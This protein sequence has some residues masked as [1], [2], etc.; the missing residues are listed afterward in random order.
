MIFTITSG[1][2]YLLCGALISGFAGCSLLDRD[3]DIPSYIRISDI[4]FTTN[5][6]TEGS[7]NE[8]ITDAWVFMDGELIGGFELP[9]TIPI[10][11]EGEHRFII[12]AGIKMNGTTTTRAIYPAIK[13]WDGI[14]N[15][16]RGQVVSINPNLQYF[17]G[18]EFVWLEDFDAVGT[19]F[20]DSGALIQ[21]V[22]HL[23]T[24]PVEVLEGSR[25]GYARLDQDSFDLFVRSSLY[26]PDLNPAY[27][28]VYM[29]LNYRCNQ[30]FSVGVQTREGE[31]R[32]VA[33]VGKSETWNKIYINFSDAINQQPAS[34]GYSFYITMRKQDDIAEPYLFLDNIK[35][36]R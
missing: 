5:Y 34:S 28:F 21:N 26:F 23:T 8:K 14:L 36:V 3:E 19:T 7:A 29:E 18:T 25:S 13:G 12:R 31:Y 32:S 20:T 33:V 15:L 27:S 35:V 1:F 16:N 11:A 2:R 10:L 4:S 9:C 30:P 24:N 17:P 6:N 22:F